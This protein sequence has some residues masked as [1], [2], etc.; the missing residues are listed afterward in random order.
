[1]HD[2]WTV[3]CILTPV[4]EGSGTETTIAFRLCSDRKLVS[5]LGAP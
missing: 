1:M 2:K 3:A 5:T 4:V